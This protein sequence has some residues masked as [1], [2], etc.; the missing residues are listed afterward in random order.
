[1]YLQ[2]VHIRNFRGIAS[3]DIH[4][5]EGVNVLFGPNEA[6]K[7]T[8]LAAVGAAF[9]MNADAS[10]REAKSFR[11]WDSSADPYVRLRLSAGGGEYELEK[12]FLGERKGK[13][14]SVATGLDTS[15]KDRINEELAALLPLYTA[16][17]QSMRNTF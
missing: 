10:S 17:G 15:N 4:F 3:A 13:L 7:S 6:G 16:D 5:G 12:I 11:S 8:F 9:F 14:V 1:M 2:Q